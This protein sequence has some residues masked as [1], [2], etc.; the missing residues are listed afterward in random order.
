MGEGERLCGLQGAATWLNPSPVQPAVAQDENSRL[1][2]GIGTALS[3][4]PKAILGLVR[5]ALV[6]AVATEL[7]AYPQASP[8]TS[9][10]IPPRVR[11]DRHGVGT[12]IAITLEW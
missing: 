2:T 4:A 10:K 12:V 9:R 7:P 8:R 5:A 1:H 3:T 6:A 11:T